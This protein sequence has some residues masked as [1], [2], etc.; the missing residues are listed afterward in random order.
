M[1]YPIDPPEPLAAGATSSEILAVASILGTYVAEK[2]LV[3]ALSKLLGDRDRRAVAAALRLT[4]PTIGA[5]RGTRHLPR[6]R[7]KGPAAREAR[8]SELWYRAA[9]IVNASKRVAQSL[10]G[11]ATVEE[12]FAKE[13]RWWQAHEDAR[14]NR[15]ETAN[16][17]DA[18]AGI[19]G[20]LLGWHAHDDD[21]TTPECAAA[22]GTNFRAGQRPRIGY[23]GGVHLKCRCFPGPPFATRR[24]VDE[25]TVGIRH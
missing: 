4:D 24:T 6:I 25:A 1:T 5:H 19:H 9:Y 23:P 12:A 22:D 10:E 11:G 3:N 20:A 8:R 14:K 16:R 7:G 13:K 17:V 21:R 15:L 2:D 18:A